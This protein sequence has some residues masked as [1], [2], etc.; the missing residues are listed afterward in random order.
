MMNSGLPLTEALSVL[1]TQVKPGMAKVVA[2]VLTGIEG[3]GTLADAMEK[4]PETF[5]R[6]YISLVRAGEAAGMLDK[7]LARLATN[8]ESQ[9]NFNSKVKG[10]MIYPVIVLI[11]MVGVS[12]LLLIFV[13][14]RLTVLYEEFQADLPAITKL[15]L[16]LSKFVTN[17]WWF[18]AALLVVL[19]ILFPVFRRN[20]EFKRRYDEIF[21]KIPVFGNLRRQSM[22]AGFTRTLGLLIEAGI[23]VIDALNIVK[24]STGSQLYKDALEESIS[25]VEKG[26]PFAYA[27]A[28]TEVFPPLLPQMIAVGEETGK[29]DEVLEKIASYFEQEAEVLVKGLT[30]AL[31]PI[32]II[33][34]GA[35]VGFLVVAVIMPIYNLSSQL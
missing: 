15:F 4:Y 25:Q 34:M 12:L 29:L 30:S 19:V 3:G 24:E 22:F 14:P 18:G 26:M 33:A 10:A 6:I 7:I 1:E 21:F 11:G 16:A 27:L 17:F 28:Q 2:G 9:R 8:L 31:E 13:I 32:I 5:D 20:P 23:L 35:G